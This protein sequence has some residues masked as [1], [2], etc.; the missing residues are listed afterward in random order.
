MVRS[1]RSLL[2]LAILLLVFWAIWS[3]VRFIVLI[4][5]SLPALIGISVGV[6]ILL[7]L[8]ADHVISR[9]VRR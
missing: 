8:I 9:I 5:V 1:L 3:R 7:F 4:P 6:A 2:F